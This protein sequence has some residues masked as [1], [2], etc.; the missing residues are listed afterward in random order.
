[1]ETP[2][3]IEEILSYRFQVDAAARIVDPIFEG[4]AHGSPAFGKFFK[5]YLPTEW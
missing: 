3:T 2:H 4:V 1:M 5:D